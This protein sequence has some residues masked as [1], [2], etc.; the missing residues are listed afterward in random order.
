MSH[1]SKI[2]TQIVDNDSL[3]KALAWSGAFSAGDFFLIS[4]MLGPSN[5]GG[6]DYHQY[7]TNNAVRAGAVFAFSEPI[8][9]ETLQMLWSTY[10]AYESRYLDFLGRIRNAYPI[11]YGQAGI[12]SVNGDLN[13]HVPINTLT[14]A[15]LSAATNNAAC[16]DALS[17]LRDGAAGMVIQGYYGPVGGARSDINSVWDAVAQNAGTVYDVNSSNWTSVQALLTGD[18]P[19]QALDA[20]TAQSGLGSRSFVPQAA[21]P[22]GTGKP[23]G[24]FA[25]SPPSVPQDTQPDI[26][27]LN[28]GL[29]ITLPSVTTIIDDILDK[30]I[31]PLKKPLPKP[32]EDIDPVDAITGKY[33]YR[34][35][36]ISV[37]SGQFPYSLS[38]Q[39]FYDSYP[40][41]LQP[42]AGSGPS[43]HQ[44]LLGYGWSHNWDMYVNTESD[45]FSAL[46]DSAALFA[47]PSIVAL[48]LI[49]DLLVGP[50]TDTLSNYLISSLVDCWKVDKVTDNAI[51]VTSAG[52][53]DMFVTLAD[54]SYR[55]TGAS[56]AT[57]SVSGSSY[58]YTTKNGVQYYF[59]QQPGLYAIRFVHITSITFPNGPVVTIDYIPYSFPDNQFGNM[60]SSVSNNMGRTLTFSYA[61]SVSGPIT[62]VTDGARTVSY[63]YHTDDYGWAI[64]AVIDVRGYTTAY[65]YTGTSP[66]IGQINQINNADESF[67]V[68]N[69]YDSQ[70]RVKTQIYGNNVWTCYFSGFRS[71]FEDILGNSR[72]RIFDYFGNVVSDVDELGNA[73]ANVFDGFNRTTQ[74]TMPEGNQIQLSY[75]STSNV[76]SMTQVAKPG[77]G[78]S[79]LTRSYTYD[80]TWNK[81]LTFTDESGNEYITTYDA[82]YGNLL[83]FTAP[84]VAAGTAEWT[85]TYARGQV[86]SITDPLGIVTSFSY[87]STTEE[88]LS[89]TRDSGSLPHLNLVSSFTYD[90]AGNVATFTDPKSNVTSYTSDPNREIT[91][92]TAPSPFS[93]VRS[94]TYDN[95]GNAVSIVESSKTNSYAYNVINDLVGAT[96]PMGNRSS[97]QFNTINEL[98]KFVDAAD[99]STGYDYD[100]CWRLTTVNNPDAVSDRSFSYTDNGRLASA[101]DENENT[102]GYAYDG[103]DRLSTITYA[104]GSAESLTYDANSNVLTWETRAGI[105]I[106]YAYD[107]L[108]QVTSKTV[109]SQPT[110]SF[111]YTLRG[112]LLTASTAVVTGNPATGTY[113]FS[114]D[115]VGR[116]TSEENPDSKTVAYEYDGNLNLTQLTWPDGYYATY[117]Y[118]ALNRLT[119]IKLNGASSSAVQFAYD[120]YSRRTTR[121]DA[122]GVI[123][124]YAYDL[125]DNLETLEIAFVG[126]GVS[127]THSFNRVNEITNL[128]L[129][130]PSYLWM[131]SAGTINY[132]TPN[133]LNQVP[134]INSAT[135]SYSTA[136]C[137]SSDGTWTFTYDGENQLTAATKTGMSASYDYDPFHRRAQS[138][139]GST[140]TRFFYSFQNRIADYDESDDLVTRYVPGSRTDEAI[141]SVAADSTVTYFHHDR[142]GS[143]VANS[144]GSGTA[145]NNHSYGPL[146]ETSS[147]GTFGYTGQVFD[148]ETGLYYYK[149]RHYSPVLKRFLQP[150]PRRFQIPNVFGRLLSRNPFVEVE[151]INLYRYAR[152]NP[153]KF[154]DPLGLDI[155]PSQSLPGISA[156]MNK[157][158]LDQAAEP[159]GWETGGAFTIYSDGTVDPNIPGP[160]RSRA[161][162]QFIPPTGG[163]DVYENHSH[164]AGSPSNPDATPKM[165]FMRA[166]DSNRRL[167]VIAPGG[168]IVMFDTPNLTY[169]KNGNPISVPFYSFDPKNSILTDPGIG[170]RN[171][172]NRPMHGG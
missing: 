96:D 86:I 94:F 8:A 47:A 3:L 90:A 43:Y 6:I 28:L 54:G 80:S 66:I 89:V 122:N 148:S 157:S 12:V 124:S 119:T 117:S 121:T 1:Y 144:N 2:E 23:T 84:T 135:L 106:T 99:R 115:N 48:Y 27:N 145:I 109:G 71:D 50:A 101:T 163:T 134:S 164:C 58:T 132:G 53:N 75:D 10:C 73:T 110:I 37:G 67:Y 52:V 74:V 51:R 170:P 13:F 130:E 39:R 118:D 56:G 116:Q 88:L 146:G 46:G 22:T 65:G 20:I 21:D 149:A 131:P 120:V 172:Q 33:I 15:N 77:S 70:G 24:P 150:D 36:D 83:T 158:V 59:N 4:L 114:Y 76:L 64:A 78:L 139:V 169:D 35:T 137:L 129:T 17:Q 141:C 87:D 30:I 40:A 162:N 156:I 155:P 159:H 41:N 79:N 16:R 142:M 108:N 98:E 138:T 7:L 171:I 18:W 81:P 140:A 136:G 143:V 113:T 112:Q 133:N 31:H 60:I 92:M 91:Q 105:T 38:F 111:T 93:Y 100:P 32:K 107:A 49:S 29:T 151:E 61:T 102:T 97:F 128:R 5:N 14:Y 45:A 63:S 104:D 153:L 42:N 126:S 69:T 26:V 166:H 82:T 125:N 103:F 62:S 72:Y 147:A 160:G 25:F 44:D 57:L 168:G 123:T 167:W 152:N 34:A 161:D 9:G 127:F 19:V 55:S 85:L 11:I 95:N 154:I 165:D 68:Q